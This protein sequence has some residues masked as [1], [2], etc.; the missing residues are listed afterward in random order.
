MTIQL[1]LENLRVGMSVMYHGQWFM[2]TKV[3]RRNVFGRLQGNGCM[4]DVTS[5]TDNNLYRVKLA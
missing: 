5:A 2:I 4:M 3:T 1:S